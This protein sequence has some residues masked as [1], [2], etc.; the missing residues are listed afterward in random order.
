MKDLGT[1]DYLAPHIRRPLVRDLVSL[2]G[3]RDPLA[4]NNEVDVAASDA[5]QLQMECEGL[6]E[7]VLQDFAAID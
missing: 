5:R 4:L 2:R 3:Y 7:L 1:Y 6:A